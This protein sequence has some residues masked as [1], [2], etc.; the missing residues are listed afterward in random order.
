MA[1]FEDHVVCALFAP[2][3]KLAAQP[4]AP[5]VPPVK[6]PQETAALVVEAHR[7]ATDSL[8]HELLG[9]IYAHS[10]GFFESLVVDVL[11]AMGYSGR[12]RDL[13]RRIGQSH[14]G[15]VDGIIEQDEL[16]LDVIYLQAKRLK[17]STIVPVSD[18]RDF[19]GSL[20][21]KKATKGVFVTTADFSA[22][23]VD[24]IGAVSRRVVLVNGR[25]ITDLM[26]RHNIG[27]QVLNT[28]QFKSLDGAY[29]AAKPASNSGHPRK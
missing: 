12:R 11:F 23:A 7:A 22:A 10:H 8:R 16:G 25:R 26:I 3:P 15:G 20:E 17:P 24:F 28:Y 21:A 27:V 29:F 9:R 2:G 18:I 6:L 14:D 1:V 5:S 13:A 19:V 4:D